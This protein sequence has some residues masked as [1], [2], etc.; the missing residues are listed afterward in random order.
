MPASETDGRP[1]WQTTPL[2][3]MSA[4]Q[5]ESLCDGCGKCC[6]NKY[7]DE[8]T[9]AMRYTSVACVL[10]D[11][12]QCRCADYAHRAQRVSDCVTLTPDTLRDPT[13]LPETCAYRRL[14]EGRPLPDWHPL[15]TGD[16]ASVFRAG[17]TVYGRVHSERD[18]DNP[19][20][21]LIDWV[22]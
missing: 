9:G 7:A 11:Q 2:A 1:F 4:E 19:M 5:W 20:L 3:A 16:P 8:E 12:D 22:Q 15:L 6:L 17:H 14:A 13:W 18:V 21:F 10:L